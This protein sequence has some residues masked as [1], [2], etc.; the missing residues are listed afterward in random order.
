MLGVSSYRAA[1][2]KDLALVNSVV[3][4]RAE[5]KMIICIWLFFKKQ[6]QNGLI[7]KILWRNINNGV[8]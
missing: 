6:L 3:L 2:T 8:M 7:L 4:T 5:S 1:Q